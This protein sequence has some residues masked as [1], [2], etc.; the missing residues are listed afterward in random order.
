MNIDRT[1]AVVRGRRT[2]LVLALALGLG[3]CTNL[4][5]RTPEQEVEARAEAR[6]NALIKRDFVLAHSFTQPGFRAVVK[7]EDYGKR[8]GHAGTW[9]GAQIHEVKCEAG[10]CTV[11]VR[12]TTAVHLPRIARSIPE[13]TG[14]HDEVWVRDEGQ[15]WYFERL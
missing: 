2:A 7:P 5:P 8:F 11:R 4:G 9:K 10:R 13:V 1:A 3:A 14:Y 12:L 15:W 6:W